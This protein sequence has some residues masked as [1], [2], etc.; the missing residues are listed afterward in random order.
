ML[1]AIYIDTFLS[2]HALNLGKVQKII[3]TAQSK[4]P[5]VKK[6]Y[7]VSPIVVLLQVCA[8]PSHACKNILCDRLLITLWLIAA[9]YCTFRKYTLKIQVFTFE[10]SRRL[11]P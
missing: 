7:I 3:R 9:K 1:L 5:Y 11:I 2:Y 6:E 8:S 4:F 10:Y